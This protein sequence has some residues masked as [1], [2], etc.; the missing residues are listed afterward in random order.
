MKRKRRKNDR[1][2]VIREVLVQLFGLQLGSGTS[3]EALRLFAL[4]CV[5][6]ASRKLAATSGAVDGS[7]V[8]TF[9]SL[10]R[11]WHRE[12]RYLSKDGLPRPLTTTGKSSLRGLISTYYQKAR[13]DS[14]FAALRKT[15]IVRKTTNGRWLPTSK[16]AVVPIVSTE[17]LEHLSEGVLRYVETV[18]RN[19]TTKRKEDVLFE[20]SSKVRK[21]PESAAPEFRRFVD[22]Q[23][24]AFLASVDDWLEARA[25]AAMR[26]RQRKCT[27]GVFA[28][29]FLDDITQ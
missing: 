3:V 2:L 18:T 23:A 7:D 14:V 4:E 13:V 15:G 27:A 29:A 16:Y 8:Q 11:T 21:F 17:L 12:A 1:E 6:A 20:R 5:D 28:F 26:S 9:G 24:I 10:L 22:Q 25:D 19:V